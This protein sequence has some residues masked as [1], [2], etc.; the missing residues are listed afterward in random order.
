MPVPALTPPTEPT[1]YDPHDY[2]EVPEDERTAQN[3]SHA[4]VRTS[5]VCAYMYMYIYMYIYMYT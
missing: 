5:T 2:D 1:A 4:S 3:N